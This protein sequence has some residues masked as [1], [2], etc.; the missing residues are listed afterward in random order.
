MKA[1]VRW[2]AGMQF[3]GAGDTGAPLTLDAL[4][5]HGG[6]GAGPSPMEAV[7]LALGGCTGMDVLSVLAKMRATPQA[8][9]VRIT[10]ERAAQ[11]PRVFTRIAVEYLLWGTNLR[12]D[13][14]RRA[15]ELSQTRYCPVAAMLGR[16]A[17]LTYAWR[18][19]TTDRA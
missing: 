9:E 5:E 8:F 1:T 3:Q 11:H 13:Q 10:A 4:P 6:A 15:V 18:I 16:T 2:A 14:V 12:P 19:L 17:A 7:L